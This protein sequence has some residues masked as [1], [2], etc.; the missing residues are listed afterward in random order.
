MSPRWWRPHTACALA[1]H[2]STQCEVSGALHHWGETSSLNFRRRMGTPPHYRTDQGGALR[3]VES[4]SS[5]TGT[6]RGIRDLLRTTSSS[7]CRATCLTAGSRV[8]VKNLKA[9]ATLATCISSS[10]HGTPNFPIHCGV[11]KNAEQA[12]AGM[13][14]AF[15]NHFLVAVPSLQHHREPGKIFI[16]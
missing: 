1:Q 2:T 5:D 12:R 13:H 8:S 6:V 16:T 3:K 14:T 4:C 15:F 10:A 9:C 7:C 11:Y